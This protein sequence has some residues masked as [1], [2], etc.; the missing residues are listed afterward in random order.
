MKS[1]EK[2][3]N[4]KSVGTKRMILCEELRMKQKRMIKSKFPTM[5]EKATNFNKEND[6]LE[7]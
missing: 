7:K 4:I 6:A 3:E 1:K 2:K 5:K